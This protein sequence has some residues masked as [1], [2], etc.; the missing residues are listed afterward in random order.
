M[1][2]ISVGTLYYHL[3]FM[4]PFVVKIR[5]GGTCSARKGYG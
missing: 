1:L 3:E 4:K 5:S 2:G